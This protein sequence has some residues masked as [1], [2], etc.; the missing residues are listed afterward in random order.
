M[1]PLRLK[2]IFRYNHN[3]SIASIQMFL[4]FFWPLRAVVSAV[5]DPN[6]EAFLD[7]FLLE[8]FNVVLVF[9]V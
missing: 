8:F 7:Q 2:S 3:K 9:V 5:V 6:V 4:N 1:Y